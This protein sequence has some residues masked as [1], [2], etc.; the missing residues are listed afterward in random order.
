MCTPLLPET[1]GNSKSTLDIA[2]DVLSYLKKT[3]FLNEIEKKIEEECDIKKEHGDCWTSDDIKRVWEKTELMDITS[4][5]RRF[6]AIMMQLVKGWVYD[7]CKRKA[8]SDLKEDAILDQKFGQMTLDDN[9]ERMEGEEKN[10]RCNVEE[11][12]GDRSSQGNAEPNNLTSAG[13]V[14]GG[15]SSASKPSQIDNAANKDERVESKGSNKSNS[16]TNYIRI[17]L[18][19]L[20]GDESTSSE[21]VVSNSRPPY[22]LIDRVP[23]LTTMSK[24]T[25][26]VLLYNNQTRNAAWVYEILNRSILAKNYEKRKSIFKE[27][28]S[29]HPINS[30]P[31]SKKKYEPSYDQG[32]YAAA[33][34]HRWNQEAYND[35]YVLSN[36]SPQFK[37]LN[38]GLWRLLENRC[39]KQVLDSTNNIR[40]V[41]VY[42][43]PLYLPSGQDSEHVNY[44]MLR[45]KAV[46]THFFKVVIMEDEDGTVSELECYKLPNET[47]E[48]NLD[49]FKVPIKQIEQD[50]GLIF[51]ESG[52]NVREKTMSWKWK[53]N[54]QDGNLTNA[55]IT[56][57]V[58]TDS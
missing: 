39:R 12:T 25:S 7:E 15:D 35:T 37:K 18:S 8:Q 14:Y 17:P 50:S 20:F 10:P 48:L 30:T 38:R 5:D 33:A 27:D 21:D 1:N 57:T 26:Y 36:M 40:N 32:H 56:V 46:P 2:K 45:G 58:S 55:E 51:T 34:N 28:D 53:G 42:T 23:E 19:V 29:L 9:L 43:G 54:D 13:A 47:P 41:H 44:K 52:V 4:E 24:K 11:N 6:F 49:S 3:G 31:E 22:K 16:P